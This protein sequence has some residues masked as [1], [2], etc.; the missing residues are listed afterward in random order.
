VADLFADIF[1]GKPHWVRPAYDQMANARPSMFGHWESA[2]RSY[3]QLIDGTGRLT[4]EDIALFPGPISEIGEVASEAHG[5]H[6]RVAIDHPG[7]QFWWEAL[8]IHHSPFERDALIRPIFGV[9]DEYRAI[10][11]ALLYA[12]SI[13]VRYRPSIWR[14][15]QEGDLDHMRVLIEAFLAIV[16]RVLPE[17]FLEK[18]TAQRVSA[19]QPGSLF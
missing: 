3:V 2:T 11:V 1:E 18:V 19:K 10:S 6:F 12:L 5:R 13:I 4:K 16:E 15:V 9:I 8:R 14:R 7:K 17:Q